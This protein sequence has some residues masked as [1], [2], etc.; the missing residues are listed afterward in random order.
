M[1]KSFCLGIGASELCPGHSPGPDIELPVEAQRITGI[2]SEM[3]KG[4]PKI[5]PVL[6]QFLAFIEGSVL[7]AH[8]AAFDMGFLRT[9]C[10]QIGVDL[11]WP[12][13]CTLKM[14]R[15]ILADL[16]R[17]NLD[18]LAEHYD[19]QFEARHRSVGD[20]KVTVGVL[21]E[22]LAEEGNHLKL[23]SDISPYSV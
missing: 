23:W 10:A 14:A 17:K 1:F 16:E 6:R 7:V 22:M 18:T 19:L 11:E 20:V 13:F 4:Q 21:R 12:S 5:E 2:T 9:A 3:L 15:D 8:N